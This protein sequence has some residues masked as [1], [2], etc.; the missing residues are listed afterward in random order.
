MCDTF[1]ALPSVTGDGSVLFGKNS[2]R[3]PNE[4]QAVEYHPPAK[5]GRGAELEATYVTIPQAPETHG[6]LLCR[7][8][9]MWGAEIGANEKGVVIGNEAVW[10]RMPLDRKPGLTG[11]DLLRLALERGGTA[12]QALTVITGLLSDFGQG[13]ICGFEDRKMTYHNSYIIAD[14][15]EAWVL[16]TA[17]HLWAAKK[18]EGC[19]SISN[20]LTIGEDF[21]R[22]HTDLISTARERGWL[23]KGETF[24]FTRCLGDWFYTTFSASRRRRCRSLALLKE[25]AGEADISRAFR[26]LRD[27]GEPPGDEGY[28]PD[29]HFLGSRICAHAANPIARKA[30]QSTASLA[31]RLTERDRT[32]WVTGT[33]APCTGIFKPVWFA[34]GVLPNVGPAPGKN[35]DPR[36]LWWRH[37]RLH[38]RVLEDFQARLKAYSAR[39]DELEGHYV[40]EAGEPAGIQDIGKGAGFALTERAFAESDRALSRWMDETAAVPV[41][42]RPGP[43][44][45][46]FW[47]KQNRKAGLPAG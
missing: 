45:R 23:K 1:V 43:I 46:R 8:F 22:C 41:G 10:T 7:P 40:R 25:R 15:R 42:K 19:A 24:D 30:T 13:G 47:A 27:H 34:G 6:V 26:I 9:W 28:R 33:S 4:A 3:E 17:A 16:E 12:Q 36:S 31:A 32:I 35:Y 21:D 29:K 39:R 11:M 38:R 2:D 14:P 37:E 20:G 44:Y 5:H 18:V